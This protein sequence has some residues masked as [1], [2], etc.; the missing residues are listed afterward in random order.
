MKPLLSKTTRP[1]LVFVMMVLVISVPV[2]YFVVDAIWQNELD[3]HNEIVA[4][5]TGYE[6]NKM[7]VS[8]EEIQRSIALW[9]HIQPGTNIKKN[10]FQPFKERFDFYDGEIQT[11]L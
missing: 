8:K 3:E 10:I 6:F 11:F 1:F 7:D 4:E 5:K 2:Y 9:N